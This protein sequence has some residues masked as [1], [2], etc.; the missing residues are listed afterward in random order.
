MPSNP[1]PLQTLRQAIASSLAS[2][3][4]LIAEAARNANRSPSHNTYLTLYTSESAHR[5]EQLDS[6]F[7]DAQSRPSLYG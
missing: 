5:A 7:P 6:L 2:P 1:S 3:Q 4:T